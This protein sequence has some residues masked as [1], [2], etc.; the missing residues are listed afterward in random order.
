MVRNH[1]S[2]QTVRVDDPSPSWK[3]DDR[4]PFRWDLLMVALLVLELAAIA[5]FTYPWRS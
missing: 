1:L 3:D 2:A 5:I 4:P